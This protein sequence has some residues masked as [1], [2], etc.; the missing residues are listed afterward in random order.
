MLF[1]R[2]I[3]LLAVVLLGGCSRSEAPI[4]ADQLQIKIN[5]LC[6][7]C[8]DFLRCAP[9]SPANA[10]AATLY[11]LREKSFLAQ[12]ATIWDYLIQSLWRKTSDTRPLTVYQ[13]EP[14]RSRILVEA[15]HAHVDSV[16][17]LIT[18]PGATIDMRSGAWW[19]GERQLGECVALSRRAG[20]AWLREFLQKPLPTRVAK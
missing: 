3:L 6:T 4:P 20:Y 15:A 14:G 10:E 5:L 13:D 7:T 2:V 8:D 11:R 19:Q 17:G 18:L 12:I 9:A 16:S 1:A